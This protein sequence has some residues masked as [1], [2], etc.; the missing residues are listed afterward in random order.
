MEHLPRVPGDGSRSSVGGFVVI[1]AITHDEILAKLTLP[2]I[3][4]VPS[5]RTM[6]KRS[7]PAQAYESSPI[8][9][10]QALPA[11]KTSLDLCS[12]FRQKHWKPRFNDAHVP[13]GNAWQIVT[14]SGE[15]LLIFS[16][17]NWLRNSR[18]MF[19]DFCRETNHEFGTLTPN[20]VVV[21]G[22]RQIPFRDCRLTHED[23]FRPRPPV[24]IRKQSA[25]S[26]LAK[27]DTLLQSRNSK[28][29][30]VDYRELHDDDEAH[31]DELQGQLQSDFLAN[32]AFYEKALSVKFGTPAEVGSK[33]HKSIPINGVVRYA[34]WT[35]G[36]K[37]LYLVVSHEDRELPWV[38][39]LGVTV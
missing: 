1:M 13:C 26:I 14:P 10:V 35:V 15:R 21:L 33:E 30:D 19:E 3:E 8:V 22:A 11:D 23:Q 5:R 31:D 17:V 24:T 27:S 28:V 34:I 2:W 25:K 4:I 12:R 36:K 20:G 38:T 18:Q 32:M 6:S 39:Y 29:Q 37:R 7:L 9:I 16:W